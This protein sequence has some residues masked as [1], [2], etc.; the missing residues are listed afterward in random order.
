[1]D[2]IATLFGMILFIGFC[3]SGVLMCKGLDKLNAKL[4]KRGK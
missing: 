3:S 1:M 4:N 2:I